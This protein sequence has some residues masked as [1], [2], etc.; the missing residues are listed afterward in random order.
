MVEPASASARREAGGSR[1]PSAVSLEEIEAEAEENADMSAPAVG[2]E[3]EDP[4]T[5][6]RAAGRQS[7]GMS[8]EAP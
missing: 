4:H 1:S 5:V 8:P 6:L 3:D 7:G 2:S